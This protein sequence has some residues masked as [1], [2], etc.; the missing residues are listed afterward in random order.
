MTNKGDEQ[1]EYA[2]RYRPTSRAELG[3]SL[4]VS[5]WLADVSRFDVE[6]DRDLANA[7]PARIPAATDCSSEGR[8]ETASRRRFFMS[9]EISICSGSRWWVAAML[10]AQANVSRLI[11]MDA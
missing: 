7:L 9:G 3:Q 10:G 5:G 8:L 6:F 4:T 2:N 1:N 11:G